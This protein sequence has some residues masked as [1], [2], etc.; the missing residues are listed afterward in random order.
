MGEIIL[1]ICFVTNVLP[2]AQPSPV[3][4]INSAYVHEVHREFIKSPV[5]SNDRVE[6]KLK[7]FMVFRNQNKKDGKS[8]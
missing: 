5:N 3:E 2:V 4:T 6:K 1:N 8:L 7:P